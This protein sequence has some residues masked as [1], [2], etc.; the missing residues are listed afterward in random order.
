[1]KWK[2]GNTL[3]LSIQ[4]LTKHHLLHNVKVLNVVTLAARPMPG[5][6]T[7]QMSRCLPEGG[8]CWLA[9]CSSLDEADALCCVWDDDWVLAG[10]RLEPLTARD[11]PWRVSPWL[12]GTSADNCDLPEWT[13]GPSSRWPTDR[14]LCDGCHKPQHHG[15][16]CINK[17]HCTNAIALSKLG[18]L[19]T[20]DFKMSRHLYNTSSSSSTYDQRQWHFY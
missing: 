18:S 15:T 7:E 4:P 12:T 10:R 2:V 9:T 17:H 5:M 3:F 16:Y 19:W 20:R 11:S 8:N 1:M 13:A 6:S 14:V